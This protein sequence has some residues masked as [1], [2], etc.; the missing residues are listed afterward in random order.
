M[1]TSVGSTERALAI[2]PGLSPMNDESPTRNESSGNA[3]IRAVQTEGFNIGSTLETVFFVRSGRRRDGRGC[4]QRQAG[5]HIPVGCSSAR[6]GGAKR[7]RRFVNRFSAAARGRGKNSEMESIEAVGSM[8]SRRRAA[9]MEVLA[10]SRERE[11]NQRC[12]VVATERIWLRSHP[13]SQRPAKRLEVVLVV[14]DR[15]TRVPLQT[16]CSL[17]RSGTS[18]SP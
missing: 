4:A 8:L 3:A 17:R 2:L 16:G 11:T 5:A 18:G 1:P 13:C 9:S 6:G 14:R 10:P 12:S 7:P 15:R